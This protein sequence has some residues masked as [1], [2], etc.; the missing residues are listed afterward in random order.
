MRSRAQDGFTLIE[1]LAVSVFLVPILLAV[2]TTTD[3]VT[4]TI[5]TDDANA[6]T[7]TTVSLALERIG[8]LLRPGV[9]R[10]F[11]V[12]ATQADVDAAVANLDPVVP[13]V[14]EWIPA[15]SLDLDPRDNL[16]FQSADGVL[17][18]NASALTPTRELEFIM[19]DDELAN[20]TDDDGDGLVDEGKL[21]LDYSTARV[22]LG[23]GVEGFS[24]S[25]E[26]DVVRVARVT[27]RCARRDGNRRLHR[28]SITHVIHVRNS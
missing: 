4:S 16:Q 18:I 8:Q 17:S 28:T 13:T 11:K 22:V 10:T 2:L 1:L 5:R 23:D 21:Y 25:V 26:G 27:L 7:S 20:G 24:V 15:K 6:S 3:T 12:R 9:A 14:G 19:D